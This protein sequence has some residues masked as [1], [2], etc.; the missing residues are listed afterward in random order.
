MARNIR[1]RGRAVASKV[2]R[3]MSRNIMIAAEML[4][5][6]IRGRFPASGEAGTRS[7]GGDAKNPSEP[8]GIPHIQTAHLK[9]NIGTEKR[10]INSARVGT[11]V[12]SKDS[13]GYAL[14][15]EKGTAHMAP[16]PY[17]LPGLKRNKRRIGKIMGGKVI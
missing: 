13:V 17:L 15:L 11:G 6:D 12:G 8:G 16:R 3:G 7:G 1:W 10:G 4:A 2:R 14:W 5:S 9:R